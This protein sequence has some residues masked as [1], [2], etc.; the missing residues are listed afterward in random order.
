V[1]IAA[2]LGS[3]LVGWVILTDRDRRLR[4][5]RA[6]RR[7]ER[8]ALKA[9]GRDPWSRRILERDSVG[10][11]FFLGVALNLPGVSY[12]VALKDIAAADLSTAAQLVEIL[13]FNL[14]MF[15]LAEVPLVSYAVRPERTREVVL[16]LNDWFGSHGRQIAMTLCLVI[17]ALLLARGIAHAAG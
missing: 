2:G 11:T 4:E 8:K 16:G 10:L 14:I 3:L 15:T 9:D 5:W 6:A 17:G 1:D 13:A 7:Q 12:M